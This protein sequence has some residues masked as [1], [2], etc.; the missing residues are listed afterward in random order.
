MSRG[1]LATGIIATGIIAISASCVDH[2]G[3]QLDAVTPAGAHRNANV[4]VTGAR[5][6]G[7]KADC[8]TAGGEIQLGLSPPTVRANVI[9]YTDTAAEIMIPALAPLGATSIVVTVNEHSSN[10]L[11]FE[12]LP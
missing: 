6:C 9:S 8:D 3:P 10:A 2:S 7:A 5:L 11:A 12:V 4:V 1:G